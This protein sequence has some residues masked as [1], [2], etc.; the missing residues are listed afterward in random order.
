MVTRSTVLLVLAS[1]VLSAGIGAGVS[2]IVL[3]RGATGPPGPEGAGIQGVAGPEGSIGPKGRRGF[4]GP[5]GAAGA[6]D[7]GSVYEAIE[8]DPSRVA[9]AI[10]DSLDPDPYTVESDLSSR[11]DSLCSDLELAFDDL[12]L[13][14]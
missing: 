5:R 11:I 12:Y 1:S 9:Q 14:C 3:E 4:P 7:E 13:S 2:A 8:A 6:V 10:R